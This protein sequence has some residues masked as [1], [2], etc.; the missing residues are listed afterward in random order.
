MPEQPSFRL[1]FPVQGMDRFAAYGDQPPLTSPRL[2]NVRAYDPIEGRLRGGQRPGLRPAYT[3]DESLPWRMLNQVSRVRAAEAYDGT[4]E[5]TFDWATDDADNLGAGWSAVTG[6]DGDLH[7]KWYDDTFQRGAFNS[8][9]NSGAY[10]FRKELAFDAS[11]VEPYSIQIQ[12]V[13]G[14]GTSINDDVHVLCRFTDDLDVSNWDAPTSLG[15]DVRFTFTWTGTQLAYTGT[16]LDY[17]DKG[18][19]PYYDET[20]LGSGNLVVGST[21]PIIKVTVDGNNVY[22]TLDY[23][24]TNPVNWGPIAVSATHSGQRVGIGVHRSGSNT[25]FLD[26][27]L[28]TGI[29]QTGYAMP[30]ETRM[31]ASIAG[32]LYVEAD[33]TTNVKTPGA[34]ASVVTLPGTPV[35]ANMLNRTERLMA[36]EMQGRLYIADFGP[37][38]YTKSA[39]T[40]AATNQIA[41][42]GVDFAALGVNANVHVLRVINETTTTTPTA[43][44]YRITGI[45]AH[46]I[47]VSGSWGVDG[48]GG[49]TLNCRI[50]KAPRYYDPAT[51]TIA[52]WVQG[53]GLGEIPLGCRICCE[54]WGRL[55][56]ANH[57]LG[58]HEWFSCAQGNPLDW[59]YGSGSTL[60]A[61]NDQNT[62]GGR[63]GEEITAMIPWTSDYMLFGNTNSLWVLMGNPAYDGVMRNVTR[64]VGILDRFAWCYGPGGEVYFMARDGLYRIGVNEVQGYPGRGNNLSLGRVPNELSNWDPTTHEI[65]VAWDPDAQGV[66]AI[67]TPISGGVAYAWFYDTRTGGFFADAYPAGA[68]PVM[69]TFYNAD[70]AQ[71]RRLYFA[72]RTG[73]LRVFDSTRGRDDGDAIA[74]SVQYATFRPGGPDAIEGMVTHIQAALPENTSAVRWELRRAQVAETATNATGRVGRWPVGGLTGQSLPRMRAGAVSLLVGPDVAGTRWGMETVYIKAQPMGRTRKV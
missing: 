15:V 23:G 35:A 5:D 33:Q 25:L 62:D 52:A 71:Y 74:S 32:K 14:G 45:A 65:T 46:S 10:E 29:A 72:G 6:S 63:F 41:D 12:A 73:V 38:L 44:V 17:Y 28:A 54:H 55:Y 34:L 2:L 26:N 18:T 70:E 8:D 47:T 68:G 51:N 39:A 37:P 36:A 50:E 66:Y 31:V 20:S 48:T 56:L 19:S 24:G 61:V 16:L 21:A 11:G 49:E 69:A 42:A 1:P 60:G 59:D 7:Q 67:A 3:V 58:K 53:T 30:R 43:G 13:M 27:W 22:V 40:I 4:D 57:P 9:K 64:N